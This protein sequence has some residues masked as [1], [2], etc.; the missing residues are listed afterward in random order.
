[1]KESVLRFEQKSTAQHWCPYIQGVRLQQRRTKHEHTECMISCNYIQVWVCCG[2]FIVGLC[3]TSCICILEQHG[4]ICLY[5]KM[6]F[7]GFV[8][9]V[10]SQ[11]RDS[12]NLDNDVCVRIEQ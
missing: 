4:L 1:M 7:S 8:S 10:P 3:F 12:R 11:I 5:N 9:N 2:H 6:R